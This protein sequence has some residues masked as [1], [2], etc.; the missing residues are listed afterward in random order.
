MNIGYAREGLDFGDF[1]ST[2]EEL[3]NPLFLQITFWTTL[4][5]QLQGSQIDLHGLEVLL[6]HYPKHRM[7]YSS[8][9]KIGSQL[10][11]LVRGVHRS[12]HTHSQDCKKKWC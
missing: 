12:R 1:F 5:P 4:Q 9:V 2:C 11:N 8:P 3:T 7:K 10:L 6:S